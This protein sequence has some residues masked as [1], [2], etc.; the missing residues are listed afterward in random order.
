MKKLD[1]AQLAP[2]IA[3]LYASIVTPAALPA[4]LQRLEQ[5]LQVDLIHLVVNSHD[6]RHMFFQIYSNDAFLPAAQS[7]R[8]HYSILDPRK[9]VLQQHSVG[10]SFR[11]SEFFDSGYV[12]RSEFFQDWLIPNGGRYVSGG[13]VQRDASKN[14]HLAFHHFHGREPFD[15]DKMAVVRQLLPHFVQM[16]QLRDHTLSLREQA[17]IGLQA[18]DHLQYGVTGLGEDGSLHYANRRAETLLA[19][20]P[21]DVQPGGLRRHGRLYALLQQCQSHGRAASFRQ[22]V[23]Q[24]S[25]HCLLLPVSRH[26]GWLPDDTLLT[27][28]TRYLLILNDS[29]QHRVA[30]AS[31]LR[32]LFDLSPAEARLAHALAGG[33]SLDDYAAANC[34]SVNTVRSQLRQVLDKTGERRQQDLVRSLLMIPAL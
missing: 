26:V 8:D 6:Q 2:L 21:A 16:L 4:V 14:G 1:P 17:A 13:C 3:E 11:C 29:R 33:S 10:E 28:R 19:L 31:Q 7:Y 9:T 34:V 24:G 5:A 30:P 20:L 25:L 15:H 27:Q 12:S 32:E 22:P 23:P 18:L